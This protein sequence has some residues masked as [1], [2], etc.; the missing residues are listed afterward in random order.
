VVLAVNDVEGGVARLRLEASGGSGRCGPASGDP[1]VE[2]SEQALA[3]AFLGGHRVR[4]L[5]RSGMVEEHRAGGVAR[6][7][8]LLQA[9]REPW[10]SVGF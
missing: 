4:A 1:D 9:E 3:S 10:C 5:H 2:L 8:A 7:D 6:L